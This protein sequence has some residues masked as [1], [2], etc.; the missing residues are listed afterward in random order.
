M[1]IRDVV[2]V[3]SYILFKKI[4]KHRQN[5]L[6][7]VYYKHNDITIIRLFSKKYILLISDKYRSGEYRQQLKY[8]LTQ[9]YLMIKI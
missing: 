9:L 5:V 7:I 4:K 3:Y 6:F 8:R 2:S 1:D